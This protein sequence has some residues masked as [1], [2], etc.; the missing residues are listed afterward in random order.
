MVYKNVKIK[1]YRTIIVSV[2]LYGC[3]TWSLALM[4]YNKLK[5]IENRVLDT[6]F[7]PQREEVTGS[8]RELHNLQNHNTPDVTSTTK[9]TRR[10][11]AVHAARTAEVRNA[12]KVLVG[13][14]ERKRSLERPKSRWEDSIILI[15]YEENKV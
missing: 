9:S 14:P 3:K 12:C 7:G 8:W 1:F 11:K 15:G 4:E 13:N 5:V 10:R 6:I 2:T